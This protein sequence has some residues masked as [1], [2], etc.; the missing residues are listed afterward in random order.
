M[1]HL[2]IPLRSY[3]FGVSRD[4]GVPLLCQRSKRED[5]KVFPEEGEPQ[6]AFKICVGVFGDG[7]EAEELA[8]HL[9]K[10]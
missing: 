5:S 7:V 9:S 6:L 10:A 3:C 4:G 8:C 2:V 1:S